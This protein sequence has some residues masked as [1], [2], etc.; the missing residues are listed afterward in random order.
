MKKASLVTL[1]ALVGLLLLAGTALAQPS[2]FRAH[3]TGDQ[4]VPSVVT[5][6]VGQAV[7]RFSADG[8]AL[9]YRLIVANI[10]DVVAAHIH[11]APAGVNGG[12][13][14]TLHAGLVS[15]PV[16]GVLAV[17]TIT[18]PDAGNG[19]GWA[20]LADVASA[21]QSGDA[22]VNVHTV[23]IGSGEIRGQVR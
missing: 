13:G 5:N 3:L 12:V 8:T 9:H 16:D 7:F 18:A 2:N 4:E 1:L 15:G 22:Y 14:V 11:C 6:A 23:N 21:M 17:A 20:T 19:C 10:D